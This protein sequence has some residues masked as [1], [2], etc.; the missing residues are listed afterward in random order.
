MKFFGNL[1][2]YF[3]L[4]IVF[5]VGGMADRSNFSITQMM[6]GVAFGLPVALLGGWIGSQG[7]AATQEEADATA[8]S[9]VRDGPT[10]GDFFLYLRP[11]DS[12]NA[13]KI[14]DRNLN[15][16][17]QELW[18]RDGF[19]DIERLVAKALSPTAPFIALGRPGEHRGAGRILTTEEEWQ[20]EVRKLVEAALLIIVLPA[21]NSGT[22][23]ELQ[24]IHR[25]YL[26]KT[27]F[28]CPPQSNYLYESSSS[29]AEI[30]SKWESTRIECEKF[31]LHLPPADAAG[32]L[33]KI[34]GAGMVAAK[35]DLPSPDAVYWTKVIE[36]LANA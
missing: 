29:G 21:S 14:T 17:N 26:D 36:E 30:V 4:Y 16:F 15:F 7:E 31:G 1:V 3:G 9:I 6:I 27:I 33:F 13:Y 20:D 18:Q 32:S 22:L 2:T 5:Q 35:R 12:T 19:D 24:L 10:K 23:W 34:K 11:F 28:I 8:S 25:H